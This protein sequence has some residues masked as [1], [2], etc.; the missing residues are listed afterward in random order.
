MSTISTHLN[1]GTSY[2][3]NDFYKQQVNPKASEKT[4][5][6]VGRIATVVLMVL[7]FNSCTLP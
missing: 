6:G 4:L 3:V 7:S 1:W 5:V 2:V